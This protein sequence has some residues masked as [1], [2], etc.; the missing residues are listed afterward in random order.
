MN[1]FSIKEKRVA[2]LLAGVLLLFC[3]IAIWHFTKRPSVRS[4]YEQV[5]FNASAIRN[6]EYP[7]RHTISDKAIQ[8]VKFLDA[9]QLKEKTKEVIIVLGDRPLDRTTPTVSM[10]YRVLKGVELSR[11]F[12]RAIL[13]M[14]GGPSTGDIPEAEMMGLI[15]WSR[16]VDPS[17]IILEDKSRN[18]ERN[19]EFTAGIVKSKNIGKK[20]IVTDQL[21]LERAIGIF[22]N[23]FVDFKDVQGVDCNVPIKLIIAQMEKYLSV[24]DD[25]IV[26]NRLNT[27]KEITKK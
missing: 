11:K 4:P 22:Q 5:L 3:V 26:R 14:S 24:N 19:A 7:L 1:T 15:A 2:I 12:P 6:R 13:I 17:R 9:G 25:E 16:G 20:F 23:Y 27:V 21:N 8:K 10:V 18:T